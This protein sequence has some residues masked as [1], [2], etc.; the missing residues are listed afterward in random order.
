MPGKVPRGSLQ[1]VGVECFTPL[2]RFILDRLDRGFVLLDAAGCVLDAN[3][4][5]R[6]RYAGYS[7]EQTADALDLSLNMVRTHLKQ[8]FSKC[9]VQSQAELLHTLALGPHRL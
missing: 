3:S 1:P 9:E 8:I 7:V 6:K 4:L 5:A 2:D